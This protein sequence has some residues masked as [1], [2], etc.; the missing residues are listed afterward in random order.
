MLGRW[1]LDLRF[2]DSICLPSG[3]TARSASDKILLI[4]PVVSQY[5]PPPIRRCGL[6]FIRMP[7]VIRGHPLQADD[8]VSATPQLNFNKVRRPPRVA[9]RE[10]LRLMC[11]ASCFAASLATE[12]SALPRFLPRREALSR[13]SVLFL[14]RIPTAPGRDRIATVRGLTST[15]SVTRSRTLVSGG[16]GLPLCACVPSGPLLL[17]VP[18][19]FP[20]LDARS[21][22]AHRASGSSIRKTVC[23]R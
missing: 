20:D 22:Y 9:R 3:Q 4:E 19:S 18:M 6:C 16:N 7:G 8:S 21:A 12:P 2:L 13:R 23:C 17:A 14:A 1:A 10:V 11:R 15:L 5:V